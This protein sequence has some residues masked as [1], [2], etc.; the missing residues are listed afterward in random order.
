MF[1][2]LSERICFF[3]FLMTLPEHVHMTKKFQEKLRRSIYF[4]LIHTFMLL[5]DESYMSAFKYHNKT[6][7]EFRPEHRKNHCMTSV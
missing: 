6:G 4:I 1:G 5:T 3:S 7:P 2:N